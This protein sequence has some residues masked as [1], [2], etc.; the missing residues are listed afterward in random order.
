VQA[1]MVGIPGIAIPAGTHSNGLPIGLQLLAGHW[2]EAELLAFAELA[3][4]L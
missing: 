4:K 2:Q 3:S 1:N